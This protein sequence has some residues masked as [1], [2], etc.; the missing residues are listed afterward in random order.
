MRN[1]VLEFNSNGNDKQKECGKAWANDDIDEVLYGGAKGGGKSFI[2]CS[3]IFADAFMYPNTQYFIARKQLND[4][5]RFTIPRYLMDGEY[6]KNNTSIMGRIIILN[7]IMTH[8]Y[9]C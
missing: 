1:V 8:E 7:Y 2:G 5:R 3:L 6:H 4:L 9:C